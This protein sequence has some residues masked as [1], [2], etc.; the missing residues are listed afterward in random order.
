VISYYPKTR[1]GS[2]GQ[3]Y[4]YYAAP[5]KAGDVAAVLDL[6]D[7]LKNDGTAGGWNFSI[8]L[9]EDSTE[10]RHVIGT[11]MPAAR[12]EPN[13]VTYNQLIHRLM[14]EGDAAGARRVV[15]EEMPA[16]GVQPDNVTFQQLKSSNHYLAEIRTSQLRRQ[17]KL[18][19]VG[20]ACALMDKLVKLGA[21]NGKHRAIIISYIP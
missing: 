4:V 11:E 14:V 10:M 5:I 8:M 2:Q 12:V 3:G 1:I 18:G 17:L 15:E 9:C 19:K 6:V 20:A 7:K 13:V 16:A 21:V